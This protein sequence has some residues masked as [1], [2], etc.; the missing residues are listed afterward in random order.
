LIGVRRRIDAGTEFA[1]ADN[2]EA[3]KRRVSPDLKIGMGTKGVQNQVR[4]VCLDNKR[5][6]FAGLS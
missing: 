5:P 4:R 2:G 3:R 1:Y 6:A